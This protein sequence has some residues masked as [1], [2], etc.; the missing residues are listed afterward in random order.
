MAG[1]VRREPLK[2]RAPPPASSGAR[3]HPARQ[4]VSTAA[5]LKKFD[6][7]SVLKVETQCR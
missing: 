7:L 6:Y 3:R 1:G 5:D 2:L 4:I